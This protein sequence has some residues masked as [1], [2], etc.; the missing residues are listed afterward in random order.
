MV[1]NN[2]PKSCIMCGKTLSDQR[3]NKQYCGNACKQKA[4]RQMKETG[5]TMETHL[6]METPEQFSNNHLV[7]QPP[8]QKKNSVQWRTTILD[9][10][11]KDLDLLK[12]INFNGWEIHY[13]IFFKNISGYTGLNLCKYLNNLIENDESLWD[14]IHNNEKQ[15]GKSFVNFEIEFFKPK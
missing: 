5:N 1:T 6:K 15:I 13:I 8:E 4:Y 14:I 11:W 12:S 3:S 2:N 9:E 10:D 7:K